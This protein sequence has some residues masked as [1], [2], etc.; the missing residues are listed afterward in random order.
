MG[1]TGQQKKDWEFVSYRAKK[2]TSLW[3]RLVKGE[4]DGIDTSKI[5]PEILKCCLEGKY[6]RGE[7]HVSP[8]DGTG[9]TKPPMEE[10]WLLYIGVENLS[11]EEENRGKKKKK[12]KDMAI[13][14]IRARRV[15]G[16]PVLDQNKVPTGE[17]VYGVNFHD[18]G[19][20]DFPSWLYARDQARKDLLWLAREVLGETLVVGRVH[21]VICD[22]FVSK[23]F[24]GVYRPGYGIEEL[25]GAI[26]R[27]NR[28]PRKWDLETKNYIP[29]SSTDLETPDNYEKLSM[30]QDARDF[31]KS[32]IGR[33]DAVQWVLAVP[34]ISMII[35]SADNKLAEIFVNQIKSKFFL[36]AGATPSPLHLLF[37][38]Y[39]LRGVKGTS[40]EPIESPARRLERTYPTLWSDSI[41]STL[42]GLHCDV[43]KFDDVV[44]NTNCQT[45]VTREKLKNHI[46]TTMSVCDTWGWV[47]MIGT[48]YF[49]DDYY[50]YLQAAAIEKPEVHGFKLFTRAAWYVKPEFAHIGNKKVK[51][52]QQHMVDLT[53]PE[54]ADWKFL[55]GKLK[56]EYTFRCQ[57]LNEPVWGSDSIDMPLEL[58]KGH[59][60]NPVE[61]QSLVGDIYILG[62]MA[63]EAKKNSDY[64]TFAAVKIYKA[65]DK[66]TGLQ[67]GIVSV[68]VLEVVFG[69][70]T[71]SETAR[72]MAEIN[73]RWYPLRIHVEDTGGLESFWMYAVPEAFRKTGLPWYHVFP[74]KV[75]QGYDAKRN[76]IKGLEVLLK[77]DRMWF[78]MGPW[79]DEA[80]LQLSQYT[81][82]KSTR[83]RKDDIP[84]ALSFIARYLPSSSPKSPEQQQQENDQQEKEMGAKLLRAQHEAMFGR[85]NYNPSP[86][87]EPQTTAPADDSR[88]SS[89][90]QRIF[91]GNGMRA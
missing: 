76:R 16:F 4:T 8:A 57:Y 62:D 66:R 71:Q 59:Q 87:F 35:L 67:E 38:E 70:W 60:M 81:G 46:D 65:R 17:Y 56:N 32:T 58:L 51:E 34:D 78:A 53:F 19:Y 11:E 47:D 15:A 18:D 29:R 43:L 74:A 3:S 5:D 52:L 49:P 28:V 55:Q 86:A 25:T 68:V 80:F 69:K 23:N 13:E 90:A 30:T 85:T 22:Q 45:P 84:D 44:S 2:Q 33:A 37:P 24:D 26:K 63:K 79:N 21:Q 27:Q 88:Q 61:A 36:A 72:Q 50:G 64:S 41:D 77:S 91:G 6:F 42:S 82:A 7:G 83:S 40:R 9:R 89:I 20:L 48:R 54:H 1:L 12:M 73:Q 14:P 10:L 31:F 39:I 75:E